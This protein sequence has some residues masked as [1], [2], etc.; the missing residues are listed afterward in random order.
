VLAKKQT[1]LEELMLHAIDCAKQ[2]DIVSD[3][4]LVVMTAGIPL[5]TAGN[6]NM[7]KVQAV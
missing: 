4:D 6:T 2:D 7:V 3:G 1:G 5:D